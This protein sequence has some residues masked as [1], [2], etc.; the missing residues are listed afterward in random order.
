MI[1]HTAENCLKVLEETFAKYN[2]DWNHFIEVCSDMAA[3]CKKT[4]ELINKKHNEKVFWQRD[5]AHWISLFKAFW[6]TSFLGSALINYLRE[7]F[8]RKAKKKTST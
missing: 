1:D 3:Y 6:L 8:N 2:L 7:Y 5:I 4:V